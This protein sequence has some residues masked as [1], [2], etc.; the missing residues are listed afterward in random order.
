[1]ADTRKTV[2]IIGMYPNYSTPSIR[3]LVY[4]ARKLICLSLSRRW[5]IRPQHCA[6]H[7]GPQYHA[8]AI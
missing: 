5:P 6:L 8:H 1:M 2:A 7:A 4:G 3:S